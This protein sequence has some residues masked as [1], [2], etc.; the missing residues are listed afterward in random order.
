MRMSGL[1]ISL[2]LGVL[3]PGAAAVG[4]RAGPGSPAPEAQEVGRRPFPADSFPHARHQRLACITCHTTGSRHGRL[5][6]ERPRGC[7]ICHHQR[8]QEAD[9]VTCHK[10]EARRQPLPLTIAIAI[11]DSTPR[12]RP[13]QFAHPVHA[14]LQC[15]RCHSEPVSL[16][17]GAAARG[18]RGCHEDHHTAGRACATCHAGAQLQAAHARNV[19]DSHRA[20][21]ACHTAATVALLTPDRSFCV[22]CHQPQRDHYVK[23]QCTTCHFLKPPAEYRIRLLRR[24]PA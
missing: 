9:C 1:R 23:G 8:P 6:F 10:P 15:V 21:D 16:S 14:P 17:P 22:T 7:Q 2:I 20:C 24:P 13:V 11:R 5:T 4:E 19:A 3:I 12:S 18:C